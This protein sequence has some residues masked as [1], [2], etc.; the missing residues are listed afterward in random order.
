MRLSVAGSR[1]DVQPQAV[2]VAGFT[3]RDQEAVRVHLEE[4]MAGGI[5]VPEHVPTF[6]LVSPHV[7]TQADELLVT[8]AQT[9]GEAE[10]ALVVDGEDTYVTLASDHTDRAAEALDIGLSK[11]VCPKV[12]ASEAWRLK[13]VQG[14][15]D[16]LQ[17][18][19]WIQEDERRVLYQQGLAA[20]LLPPHDLLAKIPFRR[21]PECFVLLAGT[22]PALG[23]VRAS[24]RFWAELRD[25]ASSRVIRLSYRIR[26]LETLESPP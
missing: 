12:L 25:P 4:L 9:S 13:E 26:T 18:R 24:E 11:R 15:W 23:G 1:L 10:I 8:H 16:S 14:G 21:R 7:L 3:G 5:R 19:S 17:L 20:E 2:I 6:Y 22:L